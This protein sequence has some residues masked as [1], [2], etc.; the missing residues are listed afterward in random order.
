MRGQS[1]QETSPFFV[2]AATQKDKLK[3]SLQAAGGFG[4]QLSSCAWIVCSLPFSVCSSQHKEV[5]NKAEH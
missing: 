4:L 1:R 2:M 5:P 3:I